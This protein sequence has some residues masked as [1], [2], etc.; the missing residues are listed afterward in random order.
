[1]KRAIILF[2]ILLFSM[3][4]S[5]V[6][7]YELGSSNIGRYTQQG[8]YFDY[9]DPGTVNIKV[10]I[11]GYVKYPG[12]YTIPIN[13]TMLDLIS[14]AGGPVVDANLDDIRLYKIDDQLNQEMT[15]Y[16]YNDLLWNE[17]LK[18]TP[19]KIPGLGAG[20]VLLVPGEPKYFFR[21]NLSMWLS[22]LSALISL[23]IL[24]LNITR[25]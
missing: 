10:A 9:S 7:D 1:M 20:D 2:F 21:E 16:D 25:D 8:G 18:S 4:Y 12:R 13:T 23:T 24:V 11:W 3:T 6:K 17:N 22:I 15:K 14:Y 5:Q 19:D